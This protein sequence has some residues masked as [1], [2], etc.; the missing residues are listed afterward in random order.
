MAPPEVLHWCWSCAT[1][2]RKKDKMQA[3]E[4]N[5]LQKVKGCTSLDRHRN[6]DIRKYVQIFSLTR[7]FLNTNMHGFNMNNEWITTDSLKRQ[8]HADRTEGETRN[9]RWKDAMTFEAGTSISAYTMKSRWW[10]WWWWWRWW[11]NQSFIQVQ[12]SRHASIFVKIPACI[13]WTIGIWP[14]KLPGQITGQV[15]L[16]VDTFPKH[17]QNTARFVE[18]VIRTQY[19]LYPERTGWCGDRPC[20][21]RRRVSL[22]PSSGL[23]FLYWF[24]CC[25]HVIISSGTWCRSNIREEDGEKAM[26]PSNGCRMT[27]TDSDIHCMKI[28][29]VFTERTYK[30][31]R[32]SHKLP[33]NHYEIHNCMFYCSL[34]NLIVVI[35]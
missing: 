3:A 1:I 8:Q 24:H 9:V 34:V 33:V 18:P 6:E 30:V 16:H 12:V 29:L 26:K 22:S 14:W 20:G 4:M 28:P 32:M 5:F 15:L 19:A 17:D 10:Q 21:W 23:F 25:S 2:Q 27:Y 11:C 35:T 13:N 31:G 7:K